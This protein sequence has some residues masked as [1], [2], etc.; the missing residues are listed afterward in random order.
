LQGLISVLALRPV[1]LPKIEYVRDE[2]KV[3][4]ERREWY[5]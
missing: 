3:G 1:V 2:V 4:S 5:G